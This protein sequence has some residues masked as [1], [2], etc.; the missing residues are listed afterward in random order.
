MPR[1]RRIG[2]KSRETLG[3]HVRE[4]KKDL[5][6]SHAGERGAALKNKSERDKLRK[7]F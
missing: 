4:E 7:G 1:R 2:S 3:G 6:I 5:P